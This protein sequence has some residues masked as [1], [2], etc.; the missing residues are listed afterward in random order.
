MV[1]LEAATA[2]HKEP[3]DKELLDKVTTAVTGLALLAHSTVLVAVA[4]AVVMVVTALEIMEEREE[5][6]CL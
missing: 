1:V 3:R 2:T 6:V 4:V 5:R